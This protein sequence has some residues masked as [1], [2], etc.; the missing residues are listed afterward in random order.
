MKK[1]N[2][3]KEALSTK[4]GK[5]LCVLFLAGTFSSILICIFAAHTKLVYLALVFSMLAVASV[6]NFTVLMSSLK[7]EDDNSQS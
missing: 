4:S 1:K 7:Q 2:Y 5:Q 3:Y 6:N